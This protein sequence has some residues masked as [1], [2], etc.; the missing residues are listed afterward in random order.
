MLDQRVPTNY[1]DPERILTKLMDGLPDL[2][3]LD[4]SG[5]NLAGEKAMTP[6]SHRLG[7]RRT[8]QIKDDSD[9]VCR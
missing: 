4:I 2:V 1:K 8:K 6:E 7:V 9:E 5:T 3:S